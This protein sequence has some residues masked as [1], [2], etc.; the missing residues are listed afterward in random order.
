MNMLGGVSE[1]AIIL[2]KVSIYGFYDPVLLVKDGQTWGLNLIYGSV[3]VV[4]FV[5]AV[6]IFKKKR[7]PL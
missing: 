1:Q 4:L 7:L 5:S 2:K 6:L 3:V